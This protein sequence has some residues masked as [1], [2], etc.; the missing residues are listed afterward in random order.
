MTEKQTLSNC[1]TSL[2]GV[3]AQLHNDSD[4]RI[5]AELDRVIQQLEFCLKQEAPDPL[6]VQ[7]ARIEGLKAIALVI[8]SVVNIA[9]VVRRLWP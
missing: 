8:E 4:P 9:D 6:V 3:R 1:V 7:M 2:N 5:A